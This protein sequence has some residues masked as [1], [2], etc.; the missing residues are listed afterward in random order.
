MCLEKLATRAGAFPRHFSLRAET[1]RVFGRFF[2]PSGSLLGIR[3]AMGRESSSFYV[4]E[5]VLEQ[6]GE[7]KGL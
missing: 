2:F 3:C 1:L 7:G 6:H 4:A 5:G